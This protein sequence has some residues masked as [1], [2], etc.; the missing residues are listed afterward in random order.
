MADPPKNAGI[1]V[2]ALSLALT[3]RAARSVVQLLSAD[4]GEQLLEDADLRD[5]A[6]SLLHRL[7]G[8][9]RGGR[10]QFGLQNG[11]QGREGDTMVNLWLSSGGDGSANAAAESVD[12]AAVLLRL[13]NWTLVLMGTS[14][15]RRNGQAG[16]DF[17]VIDLVVLPPW[18]VES[19]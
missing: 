16:S 17:L 1:P 11:G 7:F 5:E 13:K 6:T 10:Y 4:A 3:N 9:G 14:M 2:F 18:S 19:L 12:N 8:D 15:P